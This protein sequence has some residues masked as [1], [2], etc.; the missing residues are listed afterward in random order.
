MSVIPYLVFNGDCLEAVEFYAKV[1]KTETPLISTFGESPQ[2]PDYQPPEETK[3][4]VMHARLTID[5]TN[6]MFS[7]TYEIE[8]KRR[9]FAYLVFS[10]RKSFNRR[11]NSVY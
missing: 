1:F 10:I 3:N 9:I 2:N 4:L 11:R 5:G 6:V 8:N 7:D